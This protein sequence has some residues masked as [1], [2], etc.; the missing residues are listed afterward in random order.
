MSV[1]FL[2]L[3]W[4]CPLPEDLAIH[5]MNAAIFDADSSAALQFLKRPG[6]HLSNRPQLRRELLLSPVRARL[7]AMLTDQSHQLVCDLIQR[8]DLGKCITLL[9]DAHDILPSLR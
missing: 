4:L 1:R 7:L 3:V 6:D 5:N 8:W 2:F 9:Q